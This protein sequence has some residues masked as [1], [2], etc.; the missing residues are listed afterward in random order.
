MKANTFT[1]IAVTVAACMGTG[2]LGFAQVAFA[3][4][5]TTEGGFSWISFI[6]P[7][8]VC[9]FCLLVL[10]VLT[11]LFRRELKRKFLKI[12]TLFAVLTLISAVFHG[13][14]V[15]LLF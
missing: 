4:G 14:L 8:G 10:T 2:L 13:V 5:V 12:H 15:I 7:L 6:K 3:E 9:T 1:L 11:G